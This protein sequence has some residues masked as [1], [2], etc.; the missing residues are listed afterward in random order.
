MEL[1]AAGG[2]PVRPSEPDLLDA[3]PAR[4]VETGRAAR[5]VRDWAGPWPVETRWWVPGGGRGP[6]CGSRCVLDDGDALLLAH[7]GGRWWVTG[8]Y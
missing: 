8:V 1:L 4:L 3:A 6:R 7:T 2:A 5:E